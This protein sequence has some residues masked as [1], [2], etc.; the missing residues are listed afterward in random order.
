M[1]PGKP[2][3]RCG[4]VV[5]ESAGGSWPGAAPAAGDQADAGPSPGCWAAREPRALCVLT[6]LRIL[7]SSEI[8]RGDAGLDFIRAHSWRVSAADL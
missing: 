3:P 6:G 8:S 5:P 7:P 2:A 1:F 4:L